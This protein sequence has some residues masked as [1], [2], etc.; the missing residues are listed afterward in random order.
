IGVRG[1]RSDT[2]FETPTGEASERDYYSLFPSASLS[3]RID[4][5][6]QLRLSYSRRIQRPQPSILNPIDRST[7]PFDRQVGNPDIDPAYTHS[8][9]LDVDWS[10]SFGQL[11]LAP[12]YRHTEGSWAQITQVD[13]E[14]VSTRTWDNVASEDHY[15]ATAGLSLPHGRKISGLMSLG[16]NGQV[17]DA[18]NLAGSFSSSSL[19]WEVRAS[20][21]VMIAEQLS[22]V[23]RFA[24]FPAVDLAQGRSEA[25]ILADVGLRYRLLNRRASLD[26]SFQDPLGL[27]GSS[28][29]TRDLTHVQIRRNSESSRSIRVNMTYA[30]GGG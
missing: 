1:E 21:Q 29:E 22:A 9:S 18:S 25:R 17:R 3:V 15:G 23:V 11:R 12:Y 16:A 19:R 6:R 27:R 14:G 28:S 13:R 5:N 7:D 8:V 20:P 2:G 4:Q 10:C 30:F 24:Y 26:V